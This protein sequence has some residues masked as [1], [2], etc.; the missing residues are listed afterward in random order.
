MQGPWS[1]PKS[2]S[3]KIPRL[4]VGPEAEALDLNAF[5]HTS[6]L[7]QYALGLFVGRFLEPLKHQ[8]EANT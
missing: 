4:W 6:I 1:N 3:Y 7:P 5:C 8:S 2:P